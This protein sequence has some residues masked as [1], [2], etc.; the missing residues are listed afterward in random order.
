MGFAASWYTKV[1]TRIWC[2]INNVKLLQ[3]AKL[4]DI[5]FLPGEEIWVQYQFN[6]EW[7]KGII[8]SQ[9]Q[10]PRSYIVCIKGANYRRNVTFI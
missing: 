5:K 7:N 9:T 1:S 8:V 4:K 10:W 2:T 3:Q 6:R